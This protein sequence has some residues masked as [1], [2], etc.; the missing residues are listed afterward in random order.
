MTD[1]S[2]ATKALWVVALA[3]L[4]LAFVIACTEG[5]KWALGGPSMFSQTP[6]DALP[7]AVARAHPDFEGRRINPFEAAA[8]LRACNEQHQ[9]DLLP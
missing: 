1:A 6:R 5:L 3:L 7:C 9:Q 2:W 8:L 4:S